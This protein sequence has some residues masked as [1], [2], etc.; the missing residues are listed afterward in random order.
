MM[1]RCLFC[2]NDDCEGHSFPTTDELLQR[3]LTKD[4]EEEHAEGALYPTH[5]EFVLIRLPLDRGEGF[6]NGDGSF[7]FRFEG[8]VKPASE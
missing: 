3:G 4:D 1:A 6:A 2:L 8:G 7:G 5:P